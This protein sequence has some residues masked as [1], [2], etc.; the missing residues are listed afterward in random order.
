[1]SIVRVYFANML[2]ATPSKPR[3]SLKQKRRETEMLDYHNGKLV[4]G[5]TEDT[6]LFEDGSKIDQVIS[7]VPAE[8][9][10]SK[11]LKVEEHEDGVAYLTFGHPQVNDRGEALDPIITGVLEAAGDALRASGE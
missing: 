1:M 2:S 3:N 11:L 9:V 7:V 8:I 10:N 4:L 6:I 5:I